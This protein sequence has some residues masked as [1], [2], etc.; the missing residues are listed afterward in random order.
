MFIDS[1]NLVFIPVFLF[2]GNSLAPSG[3]M[4]CFDFHNKIAEAYAVTSFRQRKP[5]F[6]RTTSDCTLSESFVRVIVRAAAW[7]DL[8]I[9]SVRVIDPLS[10]ESILIGIAAGAAAFI[11]PINIPLAKFTRRFGGIPKLRRLMRAARVLASRSSL[12]RY[13][14]VEKFIS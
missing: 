9:S 8:L 13:G 1:A 14:F 5:A 4:V 6:E 10:S 11:L 7:I 3:F 12:C 2:S